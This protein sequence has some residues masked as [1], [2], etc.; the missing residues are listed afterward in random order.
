VRALVVSGMWPPDVGGP[1]THAPE[2]CEYLD[3]R[4]HEVQAVTMGNRPPTERPCEVRWASRR[5]PLGVRHVVATALVARA[6]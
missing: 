4:G 2:V 5:R 6:S 1:A 3:A